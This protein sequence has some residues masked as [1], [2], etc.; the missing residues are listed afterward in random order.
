MVCNEME[1]DDMPNNNK[2]GDENDNDNNNTNTNTIMC[3]NGSNF[4]HLSNYLIQDILSLLDLK[5]LFK[6]E[7][8]CK[9][10]QK[11]LTDFHNTCNTY[12]YYRNHLARSNIPIKFENINDKKEMKKKM[13]IGIDNRMRLVQSMAECF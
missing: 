11:L 2:N 12:Y 5:Q 3:Q 1:I 6:M 9:L 13:E 7:L 10:F 4:L 8:V